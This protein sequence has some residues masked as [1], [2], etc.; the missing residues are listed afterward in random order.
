MGAINDVSDLVEARVE[1]Q[2][3]EHELN[4][5]L[6]D[7]HLFGEVFEHTTEGIIITDADKHV[8]KI[9]KAAEEML[10]Y[11]QDDIVGCVPTIWECSS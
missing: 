3:T 7:L 10:G 11:A 4:E 2:K 6:E 8:L 1:L 5:R 9:N